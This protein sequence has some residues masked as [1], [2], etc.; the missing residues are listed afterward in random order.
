MGQWVDEIAPTRPTVTVSAFAG[1]TGRVIVPVSSAPAMALDIGRMALSTPLCRRDLRAIMSRDLGPGRLPYVRVL[2]DIAERGVERVDAVR[3]AG[4]I[5]V[6]RDR[7]DAP[8]LRAFAI[9]HVEL[10]ADHLA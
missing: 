1:S 5:R 2:A 9:E 10:P 7:H 6:Q 4:E 3:H 8:G